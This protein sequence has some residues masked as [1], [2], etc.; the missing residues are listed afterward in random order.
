MTPLSAMA[1]VSLSEA[2]SLKD[3]LGISS[4]LRRTGLWSITNPNST[5]VPPAGRPSNLLQAGLRCGLVHQGV[6]DHSDLP[7]C[8]VGPHHQLEDRPIPVTLRRH[9]RG[10][11]GRIA[12]PLLALGLMGARFHGN[13]T[14]GHAH[15]QAW[16]LPWR[17]HKLE[18]IFFFFMI[19]F[20]P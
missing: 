19:F 6:D 3:I 10:D 15:R 1:V 12:T 17:R 20:L 4:L 7:V 2:S 18:E 13:H 5:P 16:Q 14:E 9:R 11:P 8:A